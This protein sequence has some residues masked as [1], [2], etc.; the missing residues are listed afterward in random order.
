M[1]AVYVSALNR[2][3]YCLIGHALWLSRQG[4]HHTETA[5]A[6]RDGDLDGARPCERQCHRPAEAAPAAGDD[7]YSAVEPQ[8]LQHGS[9]LAR[10]DQA[11]DRAPAVAGL[12][13]D[14]RVD[15]DLPDHISQVPA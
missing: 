5:R 14:Q 12:E 6:L 9:G 11:I 1:I 8:S 15:V 2:S 10:H 7:R 3:E 13:D 4:D